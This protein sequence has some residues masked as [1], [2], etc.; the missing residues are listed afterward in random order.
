M[1]EHLYHQTVD[2]RRLF[3]KGWHWDGNA[4]KGYT[5]RR[6]VPDREYFKVQTAGYIFRTTKAIGNAT[7]T[8]GWGVRKT[9][10]V[11]RGFSP[12]DESTYERLATLD[13]MPY[14]EA[15][16]VARLLLLSGLES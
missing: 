11:R 15:Q 16:E 8:R 1:N 6:V 12:W 5:L 9:K 10:S 4:E 7:M 2:M 13:W 3:E 14:K